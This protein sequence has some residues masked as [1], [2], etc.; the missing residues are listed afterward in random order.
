MKKRARKWRRSPPAITKLK[1]YREQLETRHSSQDGYGEILE[2]SYLEFCN[3]LKIKTDKGLQPFN[4]F[5]WQDDFINFILSLNG[6][7]VALLSSRQTGKTSCLLALCVYLALSRKQ[8]TGLLIHRT[9]QD[10]YLLC[11]RLK[12]LI[13]PATPLLTDS[14]SLLEFADTKSS[15]HF[16]SS[17]PRLGA[18]GAEQTG[19]GLESVDLCI[20]EEAS[21]TSNLADVK[22]VVAPTMTWGNPAVMIYVGTASSK[23]SYYYEHLS[24]SANGEQILETK[25]AAIKSGKEKPYQIL[26]GDSG[27]VSVITNW[28]AIERFRNE[29]DFLGRIQ[30][31][32]TLTDEQIATEYEL[33][34][35]STTDEAIFDYQNILDCAHG[36]YQEA[37]SGKLYYCGLD[38][39]TDGLDYTVFIVAEWIAKENKL[40]LRHMY[41]LRKRPSEYHLARIGKLIKTFRPQ[42][43]GVEL[44][45]VGTIYHEQLS[46][47]FPDIEVIGT[48]TTE[49]S[50]Q[51][52]ISRLNLCLEMN[53]AEY[54]DDNL[55]TGELLCFRKN[56]KKMEGKPHDDIVISLAEMVAVSPF[57]PDFGFV[58]D[59]DVNIEIEDLI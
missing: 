38:C 8:F 27:Q 37:Q 58:L 39:S 35:S 14:L 53:S 36:E 33:E 46:A 44:N 9:T 51:I 41:R 32:Y 48:T 54:P 20:V 4:L 34:F 10:S 45:H 21:H 11:R 5:P 16:R 28:R 19:R 55:I 18:D 22:G 24:A 26:R 2:S 59:D 57:V 15:L 13:P 56:G 1:S 47:K 17:N 50:K 23:Q 6:E 52:L 25:T 7:T 43:V 30:T 31:Q 49:K 3:T 40:S 42:A 29:T 12:K